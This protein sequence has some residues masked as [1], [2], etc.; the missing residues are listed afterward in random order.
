MATNSDRWF[1]PERCF[2]HL[3]SHPTIRGSE[4]SFDHAG[5][6]AVHRWSFSA[7]DGGDLA[8]TGAA[9][10]R[11]TFGLQAFVDDRNGLYM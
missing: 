5:I 8:V 4:A 2:L 9:G 11:G 3:N 7:T 10:M 6:S 1:W